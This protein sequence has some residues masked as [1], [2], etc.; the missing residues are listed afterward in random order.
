MILFG[1]KKRL[2]S[3]FGLL[4]LIGSLLVGCRPIDPALGMGTETGVPAELVVLHTN[5]TWGYY[6]PCG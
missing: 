1:P 6:D 4:L 3:Y 5:D 2:A